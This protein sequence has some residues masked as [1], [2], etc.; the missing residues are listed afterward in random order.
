MRVSSMSVSPTSRQTQRPVAWSSRRRPRTGRA[1]RGRRS[2]ADP[3]RGLPAVLPLVGERSS[4]SACRAAPSSSARS[5]DTAAKLTPGSMSSKRTA[6]TLLGTLVP[7]LVT[8]QIARRRLVH[9]SWQLVAGLGTGLALVQQDHVAVLEVVDP[10]PGTRLRWPAGRTGGRAA[11]GHAD[12]VVASRWPAGSSRS[13]RLAPW[14]AWLPAQVLGREA[15][16]LGG[17]R[18]G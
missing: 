10:V 16:S 13:R 1:R 3:L 8:F 7:Q 17:L 18:F 6:M 4:C 14:A 5:H 9:D 15:E 11:R 12:V 2:A